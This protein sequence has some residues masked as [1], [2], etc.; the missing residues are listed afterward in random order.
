MPCL[1][2]FLVVSKL[3]YS[4][5]RTLNK[6]GKNIKQGIKKKRKERK[7]HCSGI[8]EM[9]WHVICLGSGPTEVGWGSPVLRYCKHLGQRAEYVGSSSQQS[10]NWCG[11]CLLARQCVQVCWRLCI[12]G[13]HLAKP[14]IA[15]SRLFYLTVCGLLQ[16]IVIPVCSVPKPWNKDSVIVF[17]I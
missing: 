1:Q 12:N 17:A 8:A 16:Q 2:L 13:A 11:D 15:F 9:T 10:L 14:M 6:V 3:V 4:G 5:N 7:D